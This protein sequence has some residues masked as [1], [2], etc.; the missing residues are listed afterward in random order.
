[1][2][3]EDSSCGDKFSTSGNESATKLTRGTKSRGI[4]GSLWMFLGVEKRIFY[5]PFV[6]MPWTSGEKVLDDPCLA[7]ETLQYEELCCSPWNL[8]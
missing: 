8:I 4:L 1:M 3:M 5:D 6:L 2:S 7:M